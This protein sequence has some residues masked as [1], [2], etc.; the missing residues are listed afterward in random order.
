M[1]TCG[2]VVMLDGVSTLQLEALGTPEFVELIHWDTD[3]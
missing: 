2:E 3:I 1:N